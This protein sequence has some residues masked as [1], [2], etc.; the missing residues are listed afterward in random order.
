[1]FLL[2]SEAIGALGLVE[3]VGRELSALGHVAYLERAGAFREAGE[4]P[5]GLLAVPY[6]IL[7]R[8][9]HGDHSKSEMHLFRTIWGQLL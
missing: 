8:R 3:D 9:T 4:A 5:R 2:L 1:M 6:D 7:A